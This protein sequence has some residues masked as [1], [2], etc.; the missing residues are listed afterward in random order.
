LSALKRIRK[1]VF[2]F[3]WAIFPYRP[4]NPQFCF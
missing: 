2:L 4:V 3:H 1:G